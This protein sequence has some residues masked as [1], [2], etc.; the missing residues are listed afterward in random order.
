MDTEMNGDLEGIVPL[1]LADELE[2]NMKLDDAEAEAPEEA[3][4]EASSEESSDD[5]YPLFDDF[6]Y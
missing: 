5:Y 6:F 2:H 3:E 4:A 1:V